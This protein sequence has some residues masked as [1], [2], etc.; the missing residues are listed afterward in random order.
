MCT[1]G[2]AALN[3]C[4]NTRDGNQLAA[5]SGTTLD[6]VFDRGWLCAS[7]CSQNLVVVSFS[8]S[9]LVLYGVVFYDKIHSNKNIFCCSD[10]IRNN[11]WVLW[12]IHN[13][14]FSLVMV[15]NIYLI[16]DCVKQTILL[17]VMNRPIS[18]KWT[19]EFCFVSIKHVTVII[20][21][22]AAWMVLVACMNKSKQSNTFSHA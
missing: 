18:C 20:I 22:L 14:C 4:V 15:E 3:G 8:W 1:G 6:R 7:D 5:M 13:K 10:T 2:Q 19:T 9:Q 17:F 16:W 12:C 21:C 11:F